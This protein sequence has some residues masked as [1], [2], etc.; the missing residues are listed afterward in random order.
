MNQRHDLVADALSTLAYDARLQP[1]RDAPVYCLGASWPHGALSGV[2][3]FRPADILLHLDCPRRT[4]I[5][6]TVV[7]PVLATMPVNIRAGAAALQAEE[8]KYRKHFDPYKSAG[9]R[10]LGFALDAIEVFPFSACQPAGNISG[11]AVVL[12]G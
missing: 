7:L 6:V 2:S 5:D 1:R 11:P 10:F 12:S 3:V 9:Y 8:S 4:C